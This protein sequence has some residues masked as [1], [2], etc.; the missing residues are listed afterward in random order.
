MRVQESQPLNWI[1]C[2]FNNYLIKI[3]NL[4]TY[5]NGSRENTDIIFSEHK[6]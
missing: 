1:K 6:A 2:L 4:H 5:N 3:T